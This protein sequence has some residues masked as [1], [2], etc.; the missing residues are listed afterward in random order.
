[1]LEMA[2][3]GLRDAIGQDPRRRR[4]GLMN[5]FTYGRSVTMA[6][7]TMKHT[8][9][10]FADWWAP[11]QA[12][13]TSDPLMKFFNPTRTDILHEGELAT[14]SSLMIGASGPVD[15]GALLAALGEQAPP[16]TIA[17][18]LG[19]SLGGN[20]WIVALPDGS[21]GRV[22]F[23]LPPGADVTTSLILSSDNLP[24]QHDGQPISDTS[25]VNLGRIY[26][27]TLERIVSEFVAHFSE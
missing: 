17:T 9:P 21:E 11:Y 13:M 1:M 10:G 18:F 26:I 16:N 24:D 3:T 19:D 25:I 12:K 7:Q 14:S 27:G 8:D 20:G 23:E 4:S 6:I 22:Y 5:L 2:K 15:V